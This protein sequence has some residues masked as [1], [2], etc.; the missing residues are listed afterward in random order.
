MSQELTK[1]SEP[2][3][4]LTLS[5]EEV[6]NIRQAYAQNV[7]SGS[8]SEFDL[9]RIK[10]MSGAALWLIP[11]IEGEETSS[12][13][14]GVVVYARD[15]RAYFPTKEGGAPQCS[16]IDGVVGHGDPG[17]E[18]L[19]CPLAQF[20]S[21]Q[22]GGKGQ[23]CKQGKQLFILR[24]DSMFI[25]MVALPPTS[26]KAVRQ[27]FLKIATQGIPYDKCILRIELEKAQNPQGKIYGKAAFKF[28]R[29]LSDDEAARAAKFRGLAISLSERVSPADAGE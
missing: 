10:T 25:E 23:A 12:F 22:D 3:R 15:T 24:T 16:S 11:K 5:E 20:E 7:G 9:P 26:M 21:A 14:E 2:P 29:R 8:V 1:I 27:Y 19:R 28:V 18:C 17:G 4:A 6:E 13:I